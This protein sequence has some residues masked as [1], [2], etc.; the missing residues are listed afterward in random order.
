MGVDKYVTTV[1]EQ[2]EWKVNRYI[3]SVLYTLGMIL[4]MD[5]AGFEFGSNVDSP[6]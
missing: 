3:Y 1:V 2:T 4:V 5:K 6:P